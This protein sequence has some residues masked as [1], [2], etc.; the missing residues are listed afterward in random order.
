MRRLASELDAGT[1]TLYHYVRTKD[2][3]LALVSDAIMSELILDEDEFG[4]GWRAAMTNLAKHS[5]ACFKRH[6]WVFDVRDDP[7]IGPSSVRH[8]DQ[9]LQALAELEIPIVDKL[10]ILSSVDEYVFGYAL[11]L[12]TNYSD[13]G[14]DADNGPTMNRYIAELAATGD[15]PQVSKL[16]AELGPDRTWDVVADVFRDPDRFDRGLRRLLDGIELDLVQRSKRTR[17]G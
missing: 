17:R 3:L 1:M 15:Y 14:D 9:S 16:L 10:D 13:D 5:L 8:F 2:E 4:D 7:A 6:P 12:Y 11:Q